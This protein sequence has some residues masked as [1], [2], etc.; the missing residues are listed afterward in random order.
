M[1]KCKE[2]VFNKIYKDNNTYYSVRKFMADT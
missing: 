2:Y 1:N